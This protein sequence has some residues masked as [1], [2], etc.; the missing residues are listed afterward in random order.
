MVYT[1]LLAGIVRKHEV[2]LYCQTFCIV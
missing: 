2:K 1:F